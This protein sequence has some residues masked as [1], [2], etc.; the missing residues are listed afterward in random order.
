MSTVSPTA[1]EE[2][3]KEPRPVRLTTADAAARHS[4]WAG[5]AADGSLVALFL[6]LTFLL[7]AFPLKDADIY[8]H[9][10]TGDL[11]RQ[12]G[13]VPQTDIFTFTRE[14]TAWIDLHWL[15]Q[16]GISWL[17]ERGGVVALNVAKC[18]ITCLAML[19][20]ITA[21]KG[22]WPIA[23]MVLAWLPALLGAFRAHLR[24]ARDPDAFVPFDFSGGHRALGSN[25]L[26]S[27]FC[28]RWFKSPGSTRMDSSCWAR[29]SWVS[30]SLM[31]HCGSESSIPSEGDGGELILAAEPGNRV[32]LPDQ[33]LR[34]QGRSLIRSSWPER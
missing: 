34:D 2:K 9:L 7:G 33:S 3:P 10:R 22:E 1:V 5:R 21:R 20:L 28:C 19:I 23:V 14:G 4:T 24:A 8:W 13:K 16:V 12:T 15:F 26:A 25:S 27:R 6:I 32:G 11:I 17:H 31:L 29:S 30:D 18:A